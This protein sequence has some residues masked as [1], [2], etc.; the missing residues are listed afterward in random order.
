MT[1]A[2]DFALETICWTH[3]ICPGPGCSGDSEDC[4]LLQQVS[5]F[6]VEV[7]ADTS[8]RASIA[9][10]PWEEAVAPWESRIGSLTPSKKD[11][12]HLSLTPESHTA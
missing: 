11:D 8:C 12:Y 2:M 10:C 3:T 5:S 4:S 6:G 7:L 9:C 1:N